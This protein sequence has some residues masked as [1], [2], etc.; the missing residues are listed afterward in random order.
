MQVNIDWNKFDSEKYRPL[1]VEEIPSFKPGT[2][3]YDDYWDEQDNRCLNGF[4]P[5]PY[6]PKITGE[7]YF[8]LN[9]CQIELLKKGASRKTF[10]NP[11]YRELDRRLF[12]EISDAK[13]NKYGLIVGKPRRVGLS[14]L[15]SATS[16]Y[17]L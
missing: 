12:D 16:A 14:W 11:F 7:H 4:K 15:G 6:M 17:E 1:A 8:Y 13:K 9:M 3:A 5:N 2:I 10:D